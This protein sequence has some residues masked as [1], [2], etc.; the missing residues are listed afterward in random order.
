VSVGRSE[1]NGTVILEM[2]TD[3]HVK[4]PV[5]QIQCKMCYCNRV[6]IMTRVNAFLSF[7]SP[8]KIKTVQ[9]TLIMHGIRVGALAFRFL[10]RGV[11]L[12]VVNEM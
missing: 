5:V 8:E 7:G 2:C 10:V 6:D 4:A 9:K 3:F 12:H 11:F 1:Q